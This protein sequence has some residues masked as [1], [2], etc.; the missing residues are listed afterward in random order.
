MLTCFSE[1]TEDQKK[2][3]KPEEGKG[4]ELNKQEAKKLLQIM[5]DE[6]RKV[7]EKLRS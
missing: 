3:Q 6:E 2:E 4:Q 1:D 5:N 7:Q